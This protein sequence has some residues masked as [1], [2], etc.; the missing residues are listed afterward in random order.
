MR[1]RRRP[2][3]RI[4]NRSS[5]SSIALP[6][7]C[8]LVRCDL[9]RCDLVRC[10][11]VRC[12]L[13]RCDLLVRKGSPDS[14]TSPDRW[15][16]VPRRDDRARGW[17]WLGLQARRSFP[18]TTGA[19]TQEPLE[20]FRSQVHGRGRDPRQHAPNDEWPRLYHR[21]SSRGLPSRRPGGPRNRR[22][23]AGPLNRQRRPDDGEVPLPS[24]PRVHVGEG[25]CRPGT[26]FR[27]RRPPRRRTGSRRL[28]LRPAPHIHR[29][30]VQSKPVPS[31]HRTQVSGIVSAIES[32]DS[33]RPHRY[34][35]PSSI[36]PPHGVIVIGQRSMHMLHFLQN[37]GRTP[38]GNSTRRCFPRPTNPMARACHS[39]SQTRTQRP[40]RTQLS[41]R[42]G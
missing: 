11:L 26:T 38:K 19:L 14:R 8:D 21:S 35:S 7:R 39:S 22:F 30:R 3:A 17:S 15:S 24:L 28:R 33:Q 5:A 4:E 31:P 18:S 16:S 12:D 6:F 29:C 9:V 13:L 36:G 27:C 25:R 20:R 10:D 40:Q 23:G 41:L 37:D 34:S 32:C 1:G 42:K 2:P